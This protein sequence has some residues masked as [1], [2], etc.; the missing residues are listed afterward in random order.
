MTANGH[1]ANLGLEARGKAALQVALAEAME[2]L[3][4]AAENGDWSEEDAEEWAE[5]YY[6]L[7]EKVDA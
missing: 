3:R 2:L 1:R 6:R 5:P 7:R 4:Q